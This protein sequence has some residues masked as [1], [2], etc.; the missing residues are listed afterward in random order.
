MTTRRSW[1]LSCKKGADAMSQQPELTGNEAPEEGE[2]KKK[3]RKESGSRTIRLARKITPT[4][5]AVMSN[6]RNKKKTVLTM[7]SLGIGG[8]LYMLAAFFVTSTSLE[9]YARQGEYKYGEFVI[10]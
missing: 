9:G 4:S 5:L 6:A 1:R 2:E 3:K 10:G 8:I 7:I